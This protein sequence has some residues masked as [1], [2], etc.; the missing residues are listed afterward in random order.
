MGAE[1]ISEIGVLNGQYRMSL[2]QVQTDLQDRWQLTLLQSRSDQPKPRQG[3]LTEWLETLY[4]Q[5]GAA[6]RRRLRTA[7]RIV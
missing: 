6:V 7:L 2:R 3:K 5:I 4:A 1:L